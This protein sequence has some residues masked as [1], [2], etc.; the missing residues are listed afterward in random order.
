MWH[1]TLILDCFA[2]NSLPLSTLH[3][4]SRLSSCKFGNT[5]KKQKKVLV[6]GKKNQDQNNRKP[7]VLAKSYPLLLMKLL[8]NTNKY[9]ILS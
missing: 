4:P 3:R 7:R 8:I 2:A 5:H 9:H 6:G 1:N